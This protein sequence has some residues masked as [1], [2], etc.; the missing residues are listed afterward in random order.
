M[1]KTEKFLIIKKGL[2]KKFWT[3]NQIKLRP[4][5]CH[6]IRQEKAPY[7]LYNSKFGHSALFEKS[8]GFKVDFIILSTYRLIDQYKTR[9]DIVL[10]DHRHS[11]DVVFSAGPRVQPIV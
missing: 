2:F 5:F 10:V 6:Q 9:V 1:L 8:L 4:N 3:C 7:L 11:C